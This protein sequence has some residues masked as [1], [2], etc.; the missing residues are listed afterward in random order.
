MKI[1]FLMLM[2][3][4]L[5]L[6]PNGI[7][8]SLAS[9][10]SV[11]SIGSILRLNSTTGGVSDVA[12]HAAVDDINSDP[13]VLNGTT[14][15]VDTRDTNCD[16]GFLGMVQA[17]Q[18][19]ATDVIAII[20][21]QCSPI[22]HIIS[23]VANELQVPLMS[24]ASDATLSSIQ[25]PYFMRTMPSDLYQMAAVAAVI[26]YYQWKIVT[27][28]Y[29]D[30]DYGRNG[31]AA[32][33][34]ELTARRCKISYKAGFRS[35]AKKSEL[36]N[37]LVTVSNMESRVIIL[38]TG[39]EPG[40]KLL[41]IANSLNMMGNGFVWIATDWLSAYL[42]A[43]SSVPAETINGMQGVLTVRPHTPK[44]KMKSNLVS[45]WSSLSKKYNHSDLRISAYGFYVY[46]S[47]WTVAR[48]LDAF[49]DDGG[50]ISFTND[51]R[52]RD[53]TGGTLHLEAMSIFDMGIKLLDK[54]RNVNFTG[55]SG[56]VQFNA[57]FELIHPAYDIISIIG[58]GMR[59]IGFWSNYTR[60]LS[61]VLPE[62]LYSKPPN[63]SLA[64]Q[65]LYD[66]IWPGETAQKP[67]GWA[68]PSNA[69]ELKIGVPNRFS[70]K[71]FVS[72]DNATGSMKGY[73]IDV[74]TQALSLLPYPVTYRFIPFG[75][76]TKNPHYDELVQMVVDNDFDA[77][78]G[79]I[80]ITMSRTKTI[81]FTQPFIESGLV[82]LAPIKKHITSSWAFLQPF[83]LGMWFV[84]GLSFL[85]V[86]VVIWI[87]E[88]RI[89]DEFRGSPRQQIITIVWFSFSTLFF[90]HRENTM[91]TLGRGVLIIWLFVVLIIQSSYTASLTSILTVQQ[92]DTSIR[93]IDDL[94]DS[95]YPIGFQVGSFAEEYMVKELNISRSRLKALGSSEEYAKNLKLGPKKGGV[96]AIVDERPYVELFLSTYCKIA[97]AG[98]DFT[99]RGWGFAFPRD[100][101]LQVDLSTAILTLSENGELQRIHD[102]WLKTGDCSTDNTEFVDSNQLR[103]ESF[104][105]LF[106]ICGA[107]CVLALL[108]YFGIMLRQYLR[109]EQPGSAISVDAGSS[110]SKRSLRK[111]ISFVDDRQ[112]PPKKRRTMSLSRSSMPTTP[113]SNRP[114]TDIDIES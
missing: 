108:I 58:N 46:D 104:M 111:F 45:R 43:N 72:E 10:P 97:V 36:L 102:K 44:S 93:G 77:A 61:T 92:L 74:F 103:L 16:D 39:S 34:D 64:N 37:L 62:D 11:V 55:V 33:D 15:R 109:H 2:V 9:R 31:I 106:L 53:E 67:R 17:L 59:T 13:T 79:D 21:P 66:V 65:Q 52:L 76:G 99:S 63:T 19:M 105:G 35:N 18:Y 86:G 5:F 60:L 82:I 112:P 48:A 110:T 95:D 38:H 29:V 89:N 107:A 20:G 84:T 32:L 41:S 7:H 94:K 87:L 27:A 54:I 51:S 100:S 47:V 68:F 90:A 70:F 23:Y 30:D 83:T 57:H 40:L 75:N 101:P 12:I 25:F 81:D 22:A 42:D 1:S 56:Q 71:E 6:F 73:C 85:V 14:L 4:S 26:D 8:K 98:S 24:F 88:H 78:V 28:I 3:L 96:M 69:K 113:M 91:S 50:R 49:F 80:A 114:G